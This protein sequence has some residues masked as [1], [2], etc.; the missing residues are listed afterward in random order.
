MKG[1]IQVRWISPFFFFGERVIFEEILKNGLCT[2]IPTAEMTRPEWLE[3]RRRGIGGSDAGAVLGMNRYSSPLSVYLSKKGFGNNGEKE[4]PALRWGKMAE[5]AIRDGIARDMGLLIE[6][7]PVMFASIKH[8]FMLA[9]LDGLIWLPEPRKIEGKTLEGTGGLEIKTASG[10]NAG[11]GEEE[12]PD[13]Y[14]A[15]VQHYM[16]V[17]GLPWFLLA[18]MFEKSDGKIYVVPRNEKF[19]TGLIQKEKAFWEGFVMTGIM[20]AP[21]G[22]E[23]E[24]EA[25]DGI[26]PSC[27]ADVILPEEAGLLCREYAEAAAEEKSAAERKKL[28]QEKIKIAILE[29][30]PE[31][32]AGKQKITARAGDA[33]ISWTKQIRKSVDTERLKKAGLYDLYSKETPSFVMRITPGNPKSAADIF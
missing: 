13:S 25:L 2:A 18:V 24:S 27:S 7:A 8:P 20:P 11:F 22:G 29:A 9:D 30:S 26:Y 12:I 1:L 3:A 33:K 19:V 21:S 4:T 5:N 28:I 16:A 31:A 32:D 23:H 15:Q 10:R 14:Y 17:T 6:E